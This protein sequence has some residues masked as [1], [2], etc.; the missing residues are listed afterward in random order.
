MKSAGLVAIHPVAETLKDE[1]FHSARL[2]GHEA[3]L[4]FKYDPG[5]ALS[6]RTGGYGSGGRGRTEIPGA[7]LLDLR[8]HI[9]TL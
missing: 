5:A 2:L 1:Y 8:A 6:E 7:N 3:F 9:R 4:R